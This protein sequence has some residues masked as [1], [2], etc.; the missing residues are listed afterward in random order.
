MEITC[1]INGKWSTTL[2]LPNFC[3]DGTNECRIPNYP[4]CEDRTVRCKE[5]LTIPSDMQAEPASTNKGNQMDGIGGDLYIITCK[6]EGDV[7]TSGDG[8]ISKLFATCERPED[9]FTNWKDEKWLEGVWIGAE[10]LKTCLSPTKCY[11]DPPALPPDGTVTYNKSATL[12]DVGTSVLYECS[13][14]CKTKYH[15]YKKSFVSSKQHML[16]PDWVFDIPTL[17]TNCDMPED[18]CLEM[19]ATVLHE[20]KSGYDAP[21]NI[22]VSCIKTPDNPAGPTSWVWE[23]EG[24]S[25]Q[26]SPPSCYDPTYCEDD[27]PVPGNDNVEYRKP[28]RGSMK[29]DDGKTVIYTCSNTGTSFLR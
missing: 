4:K 21:T 2:S 22:S 7:I 23:A 27:P 12:A 26:T 5:G 29:Y 13:R 16:P 24:F 11:S 25:F 1:T 28:I 6:E 10:S 15:R 17:F 19:E 14:P 8:F 18:E 3:P 9:Y 20:F